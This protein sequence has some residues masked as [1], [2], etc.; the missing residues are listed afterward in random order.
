MTFNKK[1]I[2]LVVRLEFNKKG[3]KMKIYRTD[4]ATKKRS[5]ITL[6]KCL[7]LTEGG[8]YYKEGTVLNMLKSG[9]LVK[10]Y[11]SIYEMEV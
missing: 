6:K 4:K 2:K 8:G 5:E 7:D 11:F 1:F 9:L 3:N 10:T